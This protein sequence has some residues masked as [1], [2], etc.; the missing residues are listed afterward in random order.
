MTW[1]CAM[2][3]VTP[4]RRSII[5]RDR[6]LVKEKQGLEVGLN[7]HRWIEATKKDMVVVNLLR[8]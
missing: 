8:K 7:E 2:E 1:A 4:V 3:A 6:I 5:R